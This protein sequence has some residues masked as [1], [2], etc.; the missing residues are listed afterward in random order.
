VIG[1]KSFAWRNLCTKV[2]EGKSLDHGL[3]GKASNNLKAVGHDWVDEFL[4]RLQEQGSPR[5][6]RLVRYINSEGNLVQETRD[7][8]VDVIDLP[9]S[10]TKLGLY[11]SFLAERGWQFLFDPKNRI[12]DKRPIEGMEPDP[13]DPDDLPS[14]T[15]FLTHWEKH[16]PKMKIQKKAADICDECFVFANQVRYKQRL[17]GKSGR[18]ALL[19]KLEDGSIPEGA[20]KESEGSGLA[21]EEII[22]AAAEH[23]DKQR[24]QREFFQLLKQQA[25]STK[26]KGKAMQVHTFVAD[27]A[28][29]MGVPNFAS[30]QP[31][32]AYYLSPLSAF[33]FGVVDCSL[34]KTS[35]SAHTYFETDGKKG[36][37]NVSSMLWKELTRKGLTTI[38]EKVTEINIVMDNCAGQN[39]NRMVIRL[40]FVLVRLKLCFRARMVFL[41]KGHTKNDCDRMFN[42]MKKRYRTSNCYTPK[43]LLEFVGQSNEDVELVDVMNGG[44]FQDWD[45]YQNKYMKAPNSIQGFHIFQVDAQDPNRLACQEARG[46]PFVYDDKVV[47]KQFRDQAWGSLEDELE[48]LPPTGMKDI[49]WITLYDEW[50]PLVPLDYRKD[51]D[52]FH[53]DPGP[54][55][56]EKNK[57]NRGEAAESRKNRAITIHN[58][59]TKKRKPSPAKKVEA[60]VEKK[61]KRKKKE[62]TA[63]TKPAAKRPKPTAKMPAAKKQSAK[64]MPA[65]A[66][67]PPPTTKRGP[68]QFGTL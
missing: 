32:K 57:I 7:D 16:F 8:D 2:R 33:V 62:D 55:R 58:E 47:R 20:I 48:D 13:E 61:K 5:A 40:L 43:Q 52:Y 39:K 63:A 10:C 15:T 41:V 23:V 31:G 9:S 17:T 66:K 12:K 34:Q 24:K 65:A 6:T 38:D 45:R 11:K 49:K 67:K 46:Y 64:K 18:V 1:L 22:L 53:Q 21:S 28:Q 60:A 54:E 3:T 4:T 51:Y 37:N 29:N 68:F 36:G 56:R 35:L 30:E 44:G 59:P 42:L 27:F 14:I 50:R 19:E 25:R 26:D